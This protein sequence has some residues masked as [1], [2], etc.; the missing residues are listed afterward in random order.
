MYAE[1]VIASCFDL[2]DL[3]VVISG[4][5]TNGQIEEGS[6]GKTVKGKSFIL[7]KIDIEGSQVHSIARKEKANLF[8]KNISRAD[9]RPG[10]TLYFF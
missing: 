6:S 9:V 2:T 4:E 7:V 8:I 10:E 1:F 3:G 5:V